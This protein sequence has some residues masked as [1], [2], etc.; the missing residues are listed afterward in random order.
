LSVLVALLAGALAASAAT[1]SEKATPPKQIALVRVGFVAPAAQIPTLVI[2]RTT[3]TS[4]YLISN[5]GGELAFRLTPDG[6]MQPW[7]VEAWKRIGTAGWSY[8]VRK[9]VKFWNGRELTAA[10]VAASWNWVAYGN[11]SGPP[12]TPNRWSVYFKNVESIKATSKYHV[13]VTMKSP[14][15][16]WKTVPTQFFMQIFEKRFID[17]HDSTFGDPGTLFMG[18][19][20]WIPSNFNPASGVDWTANP[21]YW[22]RRIPFKKVRINFYTDGPSMA[23]AARAGDID[24]A[25]VYG[26]G[27]P[28]TFAD[29]SG[30]KVTTAPH[31]GIALITMPVHKAP[32]DD[33]HVRRAIAYAIERADILKASGVGA[34][35]TNYMIGAGLLRLLAP[36]AVVTKALKSVPTYPHSLEKARQELAQSAYPNGFS[37]II[38]AISTNTNA[39]QVIAAQ[40]APIGIT[41]KVDAQPPTQWRGEVFGPASGK[42]F[43]FIDTGACQPDPSWSPNLFLGNAAVNAANYHPPAVDALL[44]KGIT[45]LKPAERLKTYVAIN[46]AVNTDVPYVP[47]FLD[48]MS[49]ASNKYVYSGFGAYWLNE[50]WA[51][52]FKPTG[53]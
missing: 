51:L 8:R 18:T 52:F 10:D 31:C 12:G 14:D 33:V 44:A 23:L 49:Y 7:L 19:G 38:T 39:Q 21:R 1:G 35:T 27:D 2:R 42:P 41:A 6:K 36:P 11:T 48:A 45:D 47:V 50:P 40:L 28:K 43:T 13:L 5:L 9:G 30:W 26:A 32:F 46:G 20:P 34:S 24:F 4:G 17:A 3:G 25:H 53:E 15:A 37:T 16:A 22:G 29:T